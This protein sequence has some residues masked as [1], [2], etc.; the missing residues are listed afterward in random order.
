MLHQAPTVAQPTIGS[1]YTFRAIA[2]MYYP[3][4]APETASRYL[5]RLV[6]SDPLIMQEFLRSGYRL[7]QRKL[8]PRQV[9]CLV[10]VLGT[11]SEFIEYNDFALPTPPPPPL[12]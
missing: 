7:R 4:V 9:R 8:T 3:H 11:P 5:R 10:E 12:H 6:E 1:V 2:R